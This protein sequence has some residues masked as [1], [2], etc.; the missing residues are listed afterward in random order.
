[1]YYIAGVV[2][3]FI[4]FSNAKPP[5]VHTRVRL[6]LCRP[7]PPESCTKLVQNITVSRLDVDKLNQKKTSV[8][9]RG[10]KQTDKD[11]MQHDQSL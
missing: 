6:N 5:S 4:L 9:F 7:G 10:N 1:M 3:C 11:H 8:C 2:Y